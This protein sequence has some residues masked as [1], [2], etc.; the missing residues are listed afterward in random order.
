MVKVIC[1]KTG[2]EFEAATKRTKNHP[3]IMMILND[4]NKY[5]W[6]ADALEALKSGR[7]SGF[8]MIEQFV[9]ALRNA[10]E[11]YKEQTNAVYA[12]QNRERKAVEEAKRQREIRNSLLRDRGYEWTDLGYAPDEEIDNSFL[13]RLPEHDWH[14]KAP[15]GKLVSLKD[16][17]IALAREDVKYAVKWLADRN[18]EM[19]VEEPTIKEVAVISDF[20]EITEKGNETMTLR[21]ALT[22]DASAVEIETD[23]PTIS[24]R[25][26]EEDFIVKSFTISF[27]R[28]QMPPYF[29]QEASTLEEIEAIIRNSAYSDALSSRSWTIVKEE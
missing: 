28:G 19:P 29:Q 26:N 11:Q 27:V 24:V 14:L 25:V 2:I 23:G 3:S 1:E 12:A 20:S 5:G 6:Y 22:A 13:G 9:S 4:A 7:K 17:M 10:E 16:A 15:D 8:S 18:I 21:D